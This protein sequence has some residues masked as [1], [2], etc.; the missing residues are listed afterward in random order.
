MEW[1]NFRHLHAFWMVCHHGGFKHAADKMFIAQSAVSEH[2][3]QLEGYFG[4]KLL[5]RGCRPLKLT[6]TGASLLKHA[7]RIFSQS[8]E[9]NQ[10]FREK[11]S[12]S[13]PLGLRIGIAGGISRNFLYR[14]LA[15]VLDTLD[16]VHIDVVNGAFDE[17]VALLRGFELDA[18]L[19]AEP[20]P[21]KDLLQ[22]EEHVIGSSLQCLA[23]KR[24][25]MAPI[26][27]G[28][29]PRQ[30]LDIFTFR[31]PA[32]LDIVKDLLGGKLGL[33]AVERIASDDIS[34]LRFL[35]NSGKGLVVMPEAG[36]Q[37]DIENGA[38]THLLLPELPAVKF[39]ASFLRQG[40]YRDTLHRL[41][42]GATSSAA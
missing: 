33:D 22:L 32:E 10:L 34:L 8:R 35:A 19:S 39:H 28:K 14:K 2:V 6:P 11:R 42:T 37:E 26:L 40:Y 31:H 16:D 38:V 20:M 7:D 4:D 18:L 12:G 13:V 30:R 23:G 29:A 5:E 21:R 41:F 15:G 36:L 25:L 27:R 9:I 3:A 1:L 17:L 24:S